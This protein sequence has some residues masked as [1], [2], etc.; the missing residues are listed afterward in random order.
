MNGWARGWGG[1]AQLSRYPVL[2]RQHGVAKYE[3]CW[4]LRSPLSRRAVVSR[5]VCEL[6]QGHV[7]PGGVK[8]THDAVDDGSDG[9][10]VLAR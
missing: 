2:N 10:G 5:R 6:M 3:V 4:R 8:V 7:L 1:V 9:G